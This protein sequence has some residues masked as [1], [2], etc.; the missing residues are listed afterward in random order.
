[1][2]RDVVRQ[3]G[4]SGATVTVM[5]RRGVEA[6]AA[7]SSDDVQTMV[8]LQ[9]AVG[10]GPTQDAFTTGRPV[11]VPDLA[12]S[13]G[14]WVAFTPAALATGVTG[15]YAFPLGLGA[16]RLGVLTCYTRGRRALLD[17]ELRLCL[18]SARAATEL[19]LTSTGDGDVP[20]PDVQMSLHIRSEVYQAQ[21]MLMVELGLDLD[22]A[23]ARLRAIAFAEGID[24][25]QLAIDLVNG[26]RP[27]PTRDDGEP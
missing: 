14:R 6:S 23:L 24:L 17:V 7:T 1:M 3:L 25:N 20:D 5:A 15:V 26:R 27:F 4:L 10:E 8:E 12:A 21:G 18:D 11:L 19:L 2:C 22:D 16:L 9:F 13:D